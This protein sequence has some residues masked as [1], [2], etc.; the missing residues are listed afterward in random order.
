MSA[1]DVI[2]FDL[3]GKAVQAI[4]AWIFRIYASKMACERMAIA[5]LV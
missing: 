1:C 4:P 2:S 3:D 5:V